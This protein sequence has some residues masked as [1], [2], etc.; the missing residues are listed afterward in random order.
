M[1]KSINSEL[2][3]INHNQSLYDCLVMI[4]NNKVH[5]LLVTHGSKIIGSITDGDIRRALLKSRSLYTLVDSVMNTEYLYG[6]SEMECRNLFDKYAFITLIP[7]I[8]DNREL[9]AI[10]LRY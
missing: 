8:N 7:M 4:E 1:K 6:Q 5:T 2:Y 9:I 10:Y 3:L